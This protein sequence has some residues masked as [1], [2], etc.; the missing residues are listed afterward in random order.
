MADEA[1]VDD[2]D[3]VRLT[4]R[5]VCRDA[6]EAAVVAH[7]LPEHVR[8]TRA[9]PGCLA[10]AVEAT[11]D[12][13]VWSVAERFV[14]ASSFRAHQERVAA[15]AWGRATAGIERDYRVIGA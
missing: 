11:E 5:L 14:D 8:L 6:D 7:H 10:F 2:A 4:G 3:G 1:T 13:W 9:E 15:S 12:P